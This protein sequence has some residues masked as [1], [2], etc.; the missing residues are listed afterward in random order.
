MTQ[1]RC[2]FT[3]S[4]GRGF[5]ADLTSR[6]RFRATVWLREFWSRFHSDSLLGRDK[7]YANSNYIASFN[8]ILIKVHVRQYHVIARDVIVPRDIDVHPL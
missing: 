2:E 3:V 6:I 4:F 7:P 8:Q 1:S 5:D